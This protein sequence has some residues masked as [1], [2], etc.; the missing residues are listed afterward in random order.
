MFFSNTNLLNKSEYQGLL[1]WKAVDFLK[2]Y[3]SRFGN[4]KPRKYTNTTLQQQKSLRKHVI[5]AR[6]LGLLAYIK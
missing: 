4:L 5:R 3:I 2:S 6:E 1:N